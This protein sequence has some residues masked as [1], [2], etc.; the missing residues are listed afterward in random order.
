A[1]PYDQESVDAWAAGRT[2]VVHHQTQLLLG[3]RGADLSFDGV[4]QTDNIQQNSLVVPNTE[5]D[6]LLSL[7]NEPITTVDPGTIV[8]P[9]IYQVEADIRTGDPV[10]IAGPDGFSTELTVA[11]FARD[12]IMN[13]AVTSSKRLAVSAADLA[14]VRAH[15]GQEEHLIEFWL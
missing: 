14:D 7:E 9:V 4:A 8:L 2:E 12:S 15:T 6:L 5:R 10:T 1:G 13:P 3:I 11:A